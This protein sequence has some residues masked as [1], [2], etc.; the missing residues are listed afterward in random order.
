VNLVPNDSTPLDGEE[1]QG[2]RLSYVS[3]RRELNVA[4]SRNVEAGVRWAGKAR[5]VDEVLDISF[6]KALHLAMFGDVWRWAGTF[7]KTD[8]NIGVPWWE[9]TIALTQLTLDVTAWV[10]GGSLAWTA[11]EI[12]VRFHHR[13]VAIHPFPNGNGRH[14]RLAADLLVEALGEQRFSWG[15]VQ[16]ADP[17]ITRASYITA[18]QSADR[19]DMSLILNFARS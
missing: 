13:L 12:G 5:R 16:L 6:L 7:R 10:S 17:S 11:D 8:K 1:L 15:R 9:I 4:E 14:S 19:N 18:L 3:S 2:L